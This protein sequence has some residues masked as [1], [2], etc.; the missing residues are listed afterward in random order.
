MHALKLIR[1][2]PHMDTARREALLINVERWTEWPQ[3]ILSLALIPIL[4]VPHLF[5]VSSS[6]VTM[7]DDLDY[8]I[9]GVFIAILLISVAIAPRR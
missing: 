7:L 9:W 5:A 1:E 2:E 4:L 8:L 3:T 6:T